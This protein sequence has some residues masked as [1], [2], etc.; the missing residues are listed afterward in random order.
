MKDNYDL[1]NEE[2]RRAANEEEARERYEA[3]LAHCDICHRAIYPGEEFFY[4]DFESHGF[5]NEYYVCD[6]CHAAAAER[7]YET[8]E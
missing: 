1:W 7:L 8:D 4:F 6:K 2:D 5:H 3:T